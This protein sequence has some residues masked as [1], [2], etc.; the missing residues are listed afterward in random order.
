MNWMY[1]ISA[2]KLSNMLYALVPFGLLQVIILLSPV[3]GLSSSSVGITSVPRVD[4]SIFDPNVHYQRHHPNGIPY[5]TPV[6]VENVLSKEMC[7]RACD[8]MIHEL[9]GNIVDLQRKTKLIDEDGNLSIG[10]KIVK[11]QLGDAFGFMMESHRNDSF[12]CFCE[13]L[14]DEN[15]NES[16]VGLK[17]LFLRAK[18]KLFDSCKDESG[19]GGGDD[20]SRDLFEFFP[21]DMKPSDCVVVAGEG[22]TSTVSED[23][24]IMDHYI[25]MEKYYIFTR[26]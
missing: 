23:L 12:F 24:C 3:L 4:G 1:D 7:E 11:C 10:T 21:E 18:N 19:G 15:E 26:E 13:G 22:A 5:E 14:L 6:L 9:G 16:M 25:H 2:L 8:T 20:S 17:D